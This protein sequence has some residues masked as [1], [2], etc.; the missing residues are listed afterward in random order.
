MTK[1][2]PKLTQ[3]QK[4]F[5][6]YY[7]KTDN[8]T[9]SYK[10]A[11]YSANSDKVAGVQGH[12]LLKNAK[13]REYLDEA[14]GKIDKKR[15]MGVEEALELFTDIARGTITEQVVTAS[16]KLV[17]RPPDIKDRH[18][19]AGELLRRFSRSNNDQLK[20]R[21]LEAQIKKAE[22]ETSHIETGITKIV[23]VDEWKK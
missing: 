7:I 2:K 3:K 9:Q 15:I 12:K 4:A 13:V 18:R 1:K 6:D 10:M 16:G 11:G 21:L 22:A 17:E 19:A 5:C 8:A 23:V 20:D 14:L